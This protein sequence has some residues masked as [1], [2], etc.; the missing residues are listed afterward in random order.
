MTQ[1]AGRLQRHYA[2]KREI[3]IL[4]YVDHDVPVLRRMHAKCLKAYAAL[5]C[6]EQRL[7]AP[8]PDGR[9]AQLG[10]RQLTP[11][12]A[13]ACRT[14][15]VASAGKSG[16]DDNSRSSWRVCL[17]QRCKPPRIVSPQASFDAEHRTDA[18]VHG[19]RERSG[20]V[21]ESRSKEDR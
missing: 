3:R 2:A 16:A 5:G 18:P 9:D 8:V 1:Y 12:S 7:T 11:A 13:R 19:A 15:L 14:L 10:V 21:G 17:R 20:D 4:D 6:D